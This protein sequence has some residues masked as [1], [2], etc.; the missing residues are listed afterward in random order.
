MR[1]RRERHGGASSDGPVMVMPAHLPDVTDTADLGRKGG[2]SRLDAILALTAMSGLPP[3]IRR[4]RVP[5]PGADNA[6][7]AGY[8]V[9]RRDNDGVVEP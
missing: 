1:K 5:I 2:G 4:I 6:E 7:L 9:M 8:V 3:G